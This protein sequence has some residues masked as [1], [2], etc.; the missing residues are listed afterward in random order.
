MA[1]R[2]Q[3]LF[4]DAGEFDRAFAVKLNCPYGVRSMMKFE[5]NAR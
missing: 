5:E 4:F 1:G 3:A 2:F